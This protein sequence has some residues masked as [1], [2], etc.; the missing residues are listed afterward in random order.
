MEEGPTLDFKREQYRFDKA[1]YKDKSE[2][3]KDILASA[4]TRRDRTAYILIGV[5]ELKGGRS[6]VTG[7]DDHLEDASLHQFV[8]SKTN[9][10]VTFSYEAVPI[11]GKA[12]GVISIPTQARPVYVKEKY[13]KVDAEKVYIRDGSSTRPASPDEVAVMGLGNPPK[14]TVEWG[15]AIEQ[16]VYPSDYVHRST[17]LKLPKWFQTCIGGRGHYDFEAL[18]LELGKDPAVYEGGKFTSVR[19]R[20]MWKP[21]GL[22][23]YNNSGSVGE[24]VRFT[25]ILEDRCDVRLEPPE[26]DGSYYPLSVK[27]LPGY[28]EIQWLYSKSGVEIAVEVGHI[29]P[30]EYVSAGHGLRFSAKKTEKLIWMGR[31][32]ADNMPEPIECLLPLQVEY[33]E[34]EIKPQDL[35]YSFMRPYSEWLP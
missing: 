31:F 34:R 23:F 20:A 9:R 2:F 6:K 13:G 12:I 8:N 14:L 11:E 4:N 1:T 18:A 21:L 24:N 32:V 33:E 22:R 28:K 27:S 35:D 15:N 19:E 17:G 3:L 10:P 29:R 25:A 16:A 30:G 26:S 5:E 7:V